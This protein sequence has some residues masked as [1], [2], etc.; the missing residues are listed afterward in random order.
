MDLNLVQ[1]INSKNKIKNMQ[2]F[3]EFQKV[4]FLNLIRCLCHEVDFMI[5]SKTSS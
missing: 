2:V 1:E 4:V 5:G 3:G